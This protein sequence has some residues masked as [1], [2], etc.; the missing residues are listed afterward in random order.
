M[1][2]PSGQGA[3]GTRAG[4]TTSPQR[5]DGHEPKREDEDDEEMWFLTTIAAAV[6]TWAKWPLLALQCSVCILITHAQLLLTYA[7]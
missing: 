4:H 5:R 6:N 7:Q 1:V 3:E 2:A